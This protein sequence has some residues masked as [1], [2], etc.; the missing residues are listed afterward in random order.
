MQRVIWK[1]CIRKIIR[2]S[3]TP[4]WNLIRSLRWWSVGMVHDYIHE[5]IT[6]C[7]N[8]TFRNLYRRA[9]QYTP[10]SIWQNLRNMNQIF[11][12]HEPRWTWTLGTLE[13]SIIR[14]YVH[15][16]SLLVTINRW[17]WLRT[18]PYSIAY[19]LVETKFRNL[20]RDANQNT[21]T[22]DSKSSRTSQ[23]AA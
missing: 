7:S 8:D 11:K 19:A 4:N 10:T 1:I 14:E 12:K 13:Q 20:Y 5:C 22:S 23:A 21:P 16:C 2:K 3:L 17:V 18:V 15:S 6:L 9:T